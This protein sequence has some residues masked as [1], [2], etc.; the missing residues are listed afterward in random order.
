VD[1]IVMTTQ[2]RTTLPKKIMGSVTEQVLHAS[3]CPVLS[4]PVE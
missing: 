1:L 3:P 2:G 4:I